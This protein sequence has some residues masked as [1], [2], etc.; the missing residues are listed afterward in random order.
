[1]IKVRRQWR[2]CSPPRTSVRR[3]SR[4]GRDARRGRT[5]APAAGRLGG[6]SQLER[7]GLEGVSPRCDQRSRKPQDGRVLRACCRSSPQRGMACCRHLLPR[8]R[9]SGLH[10]T[11]RSLPELAHWCEGLV[12]GALLTVPPGSLSS[13]WGSRSPWKSVRLVDLGLRQTTSR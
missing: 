12:Y 13:G 8:S 3:R 2:A 4:G 1:M 9:F 10:S 6:H 11:R 5:S 7:G